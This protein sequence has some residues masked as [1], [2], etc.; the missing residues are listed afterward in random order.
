MVLIVAAVLLILGALLASIQVG[1]NYFA[2]QRLQKAADLA[3]LSAVQAMSGQCDP[4]QAVDVVARAIAGLNGVSAADAQPTIECGRW[5]RVSADQPWNEEIQAIR[6]GFKPAPYPPA[7]P[8]GAP[9]FTPRSAYTGTQPLNAVRVKMR[10]DLVSFLPRLFGGGNASSEPDAGASAVA[11]AVVGP[12]TATFSVGARL[13]SLKEDTGLVPVLLKS[14]GLDPQD[15]RLLDSEG[16][17]NAKITPAGLLQELGLPTSI[18]AGVGT[19]DQLT[20]LQ[21]LSLGT[22]L[23]AYLTALDRTQT[24][25][26]DVGVVRSVFSTIGEDKLTLPVKLLG[27]GGVMLYTTSANLSSALNAQL[28]VMDLIGTSAIVA[29]G[30]NLLNLDASVV[31]GVVSLKAQVVNP[32]TIGLAI[33]VYDDGH[34]CVVSNSQV[35]LKLNLKLPDLLVLSGSLPITISAANSDAKLTAID[36][37]NQQGYFNT[38]ASTAN[39]C[40]GKLPAG[41]LC[42]PAGSGSS[43]PEYVDFIKILFGTVTLQVRA[44]INLASGADWSP[45][46]AILEGHSLT[47]NGNSGPW[48]TQIQPS[49]ID[50]SVHLLGLG[51]PLDGVL[52][53]LVTGVNTLLTPLLQEVLMPLLGGSLNETDIRLYDITPA[54]PYLVQ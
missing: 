21:Q 8:Q 43:Q 22:V 29:N 16:L 17:A 32:P 1:Y 25:A 47:F 23:N 13:L 36:S 42:R 20:K 48:R 3:A 52:G 18:L 4:G 30:Q 2:Q 41:A 11:T 14:L 37:E 5:G 26:V 51:I 45:P 33:P 6:C 35:Q 39:L 19:P 9:V 31:P 28:N 24:A 7:A 53:P 54:T 49:E 15:V 27:E 44:N 10:A 40:I 38:K 34:P 12:E 46:K 50:T